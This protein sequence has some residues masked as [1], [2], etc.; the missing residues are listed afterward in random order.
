MVSMGGGV[1]FPYRSQE[2]CRRTERQPQA[3]TQNY[4]SGQGCRIRKNHLL[5]SAELA[6]EISA[7]IATAVL[8][9]FLKCV[10]IS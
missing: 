9:L 10:L 3:L 6:D 7:V 1:L 8:R 5:P 4:E 2:H